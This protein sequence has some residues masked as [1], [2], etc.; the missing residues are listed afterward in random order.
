ML[1]FVACLAC[2]E[3]SW[4]NLVAELIKLLSFL[5]T[6]WQK[7]A[8]SVI[9]PDAWVIMTVHRLNQY[10]LLLPVLASI[11]AALLHSST[12]SFNFENGKNVSPLVCISITYTLTRTLLALLTSSVLTLSFASTIDFLISEL[13]PDVENVESNKLLNASLSSCF[14]TTS[15]PCSSTV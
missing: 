7:R 3:P 1:N 8:P 6:V 10:S 14:S 12:E 9:L 13:I 4:A 15:W 5:F 11:S 2:L